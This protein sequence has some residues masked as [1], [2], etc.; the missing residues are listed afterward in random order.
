M[1]TNYHS[2]L[3]NDQIHN[4]KDFSV[5][6]K[7]SLITKTQS[8]ELKWKPSTF[9]LSSTVTCVADVGGTLN[10]SYWVLYSTDNT[11][12]Y[13]VWYN[14]ASAGDYNSDNCTLVEI[15]IA[16]SDTAATIATATASA[17]NALPGITAVSSTPGQVLITGIN[18]ANKP[19]DAANTGFGILSTETPVGEEYL[20]TDSSGNIKWGTAPGGGGCSNVFS[21]ITTTP[22]SETVSATGCTDNLVIS[23]MNNTRITGTAPDTIQIEAIENITFRGD[24][25]SGLEAG[26]E[27]VFDNSN[28]RGNRFLTAMTGTALAPAAIL[29]AAVATPAPV[30]KVVSFSGFGS[31]NGTGEFYISLWRFPVECSAT[32]EGNV[33]GDLVGTVKVS[34]AG[35]AATMCWTVPITTL[36]YGGYDMLVPSFR[37][38]E[39][40]LSSARVVAKLRII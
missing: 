37:W 13:H 11:T 24:T 34:T 1:A 27:Y 38:T 20:Q 16:A 2:N 6:H 10:N 26:T 30:G 18:T 14:V 25:T 33:T 12:T 23:Q 5:A 40:T 36:T 29:K 31:A 32:V 21:T 9:S 4:P 17:L 8:G 28:T 7:N 19:F 15:A 39:S 3:P 35:N 22:V